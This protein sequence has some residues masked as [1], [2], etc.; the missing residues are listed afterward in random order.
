MKKQMKKI[1]AAALV[2]V[3]MV[4]FAA[5]AFAQSYVVKESD[6]LWT[7]SKN[8]NLPL[9]MVLAANAS[10]DPLNLQAGQAINLPDPSASPAPHTYRVS[11]DDTFWGIS[12]KFNIP[13]S[14]LLAAN[15]NIEPT[16]LAGGMVVKFTANNGEVSMRT[17]HSN[18]EQR[19]SVVN[20]IAQASDSAQ[21]SVVQPASNGQTGKTYSMTAT[22]YS[23]GAEENN[24]SANLDYMGNHLKLGTIAV[25]PSVIPLGSKVLISGYDCSLLPKGGLVATASDVGG[26]IKGNRVDIY[27]PGTSS[28]VDNFGMQNVTVKVLK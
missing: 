5:P 7:I 4:S 28:Q 11:D 6:T 15:P 3:P 27:L 17:V 9:N 2:S 12:K 19:E 21:G 26:A 8:H 13:L 14:D 16:Q 1:M 23:G 18:T 22:A 25:D 10:V 20:D 24:S